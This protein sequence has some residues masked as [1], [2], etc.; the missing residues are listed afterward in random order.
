MIEVVIAAGVLSIVVVAAGSFF[1]QQ[2]KANNFLDFQS[3]RSQLRLTLL[4]QFLNNP[5][6]CQCLFAGANTFP[7]AGTSALTGVAPTTLGQYAFVS[8]GV[9]STA[10]IPQPFLT[11]AGVDSV[12]TKSISLT[13]IVNVSGTYTGILQINMQSM[14][15]VIGPSTI[16]LT[17]PVA[18]TTSPATAATVNFVSCSSSNSGSIPLGTCAAGLLSTGYDV[19]TGALVCQP[20]TYQ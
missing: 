15:D 13:N 4:G 5:N 18:V 8:P 19:T 9:C 11:A 20:P 12:Q 1:S 6:N 16:S 2:T 7:I 17:I 3:K 10:T 14:K